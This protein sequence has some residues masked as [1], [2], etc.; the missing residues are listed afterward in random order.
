M[1][2]SYISVFDLS[3]KNIRISCQDIYINVR[4]RQS[5]NKKTLT[6]VKNMVS[7]ISSKKPTKP[8]SRPSDCANCNLD[9]SLELQRFDKDEYLGGSNRV[10]LASKNYDF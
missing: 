3:R 10:T 2:N 5:Y 9:D 1:E 4:L 6:W 8:L 7:K